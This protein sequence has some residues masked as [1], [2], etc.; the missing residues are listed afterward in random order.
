VEAP[1]TTVVFATEPSELPKS[2]L[3][4]TA[5]NVVI[6]RS[7]RF[8]SFLIYSMC[9]RVH[10][11][12]NSHTGRQRYTWCGE[13]K[14]SRQIR[15][16]QRQKTPLTKWPFFRLVWHFCRNGT[17]TAS[18]T[19]KTKNWGRIVCWLFSPFAYKKLK[20]NPSRGWSCGCY[21]T[22]EWATGRRMCVLVRPVNMPEMKLKSVSNY[23]KLPEMRNTNSSV[24]WNGNL[25][26]ALDCVLCL[27]RGLH[28]RVSLIDSLSY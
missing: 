21:V 17:H 7:L 6:L 13:A 3:W 24:S 12:H 25:D 5:E 18:Q 14:V 16:Y 27:S 4:A 2:L 10:P 15:V 20:R 9:V 1:P 22:D 8:V 11:I 26:G 23:G 19:T 28:N